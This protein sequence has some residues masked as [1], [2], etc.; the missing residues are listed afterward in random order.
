MN[1][2]EL[3]FVTIATILY[4]ACFP[5]NPLVFTGVIETSFYLPRFIA[6]WIIWAIGMVLVMTPIVVF[7]RRGGVPAGKSY[8]HTTTIVHTGIYSVVRH[9]QYAGGIISIFITCILWYP[10]WLF[11]VLGIAGTTLTYLSAREEDK[12]LVKKFGN[13][14]IDYMHSVPGFNICLGIVR[15]FKNRK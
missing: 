14:Y 13:D 1:K 15:K 2:K 11:A 6:G 10:H 12:R 9:P 4:I 5:F 8:I 3:V 7:P